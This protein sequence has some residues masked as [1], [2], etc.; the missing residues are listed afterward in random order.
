M[1]SYIPN[2]HF[3]FSGNVEKTLW[4][5]LSQQRHTSPFFTIVYL[6]AVGFQSYG[7]ALSL[8]AP[9]LRI[10]GFVAGVIG[11][12]ILS[13]V[14][15]FRTNKDIFQIVGIIKK[16]RPETLQLDPRNP[17]KKNSAYAIIST[18]EYFLNHTLRW[19]HTRSTEHYPASVIRSVYKQHHA[20]ALF[21]EMTSICILLLLGMF[22]DHPIVRIPAGAS[23]LLLFAIFVV[24]AGACCLYVLAGQMEDLFL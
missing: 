13:M 8:G 24:L 15:F 3:S 7:G 9:G 16:K 10:A 21:I 19:R 6:C 17:H 5:L 22:M 12:L 18:A 2:A 20:N 4:C 11:M 1:T 14:Y 23:I